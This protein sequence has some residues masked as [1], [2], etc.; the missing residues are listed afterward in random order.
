[1]QDKVS[2]SG[3][4]A[5]VGAAVEVNAWHVLVFL[6]YSTQAERVQL[7]FVPEQALEEW[8]MLLLAKVM[9]ATAVLG[10]LVHLPRSHVSLQAPGQTQP[11]VVCQPAVSASE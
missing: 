6:G 3:V 10:I 11:Q 4:V 9:M 1:V 2:G 7:L 8:H 5:A